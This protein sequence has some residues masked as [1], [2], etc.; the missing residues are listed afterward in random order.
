MNYF[1]QFISALVIFFTREIFFYNGYFRSK[2]IQFL[3]VIVEKSKNWNFV[4]GHNFIKLV[5]AYF[6]T[7]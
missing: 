4:G 3:A 7:L 1:I 5:K 6:G 2:G